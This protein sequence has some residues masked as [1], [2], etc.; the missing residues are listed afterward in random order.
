[1]PPPAAA[2]AVPEVPLSPVPPQ[3]S[4]V[5]VRASTAQASGDNTELLGLRTEFLG[6]LSGAAK[7]IKD[8]SELS[9]QQSKDMGKLIKAVGAMNVRQDGLEHNQRELWNNQQNDRK[10][11]NRFQVYQLQTNEGVNSRLEALELENALRNGGGAVS[12]PA[13]PPNASATASAV[14]AE[15]AD[16]SSP[17]PAPVPQVFAS[18]PA[19]SADQEM[20]DS[21]PSNEVPSDASKKMPSGAG[22]ATPQASAVTSNEAASSPFAS[23]SASSSVQAVTSPKKISATCSSHIKTT[24]PTKPTF[25]FGSP[26]NEAASSS[27][28]ASV[29][30]SSSVPVVASPKKISASCSSGAKTTT[31]T[32]PTFNMGFTPPKEKPN[33]KN[34]IKGRK[35]TTRRSPKAT[36]RSPSASS[37]SKKKA[38][39][40][41]NNLVAEKRK[42]TAAP[43]PV[44]NPASDISKS[45]TTKASNSAPV[46]RRYG[47]QLVNGAVRDW[48]DSKH[49][50]RIFCA[51]EL[52]AVAGSAFKYD[53]VS[54]YCA[55]LT[56]GLPNNF[57]KVA[58][59]FQN[60]VVTDSYEKL[61]NEYIT[62]LKTFR[63]GSEERFEEEIKKGIDIAKLK[64]GM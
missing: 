63:C 64:G 46:A 24:T 35:N 5:P 30:A 56:S 2:A 59:L 17:A 6:Y 48:D 21:A 41:R 32:E 43:S 10:I 45:V 18:Q 4:P 53:N 50:T 13:P 61:V 27:P 16:S 33:P 38:N 49:W 15:M 8:Q 55:E 7:C 58:V 20:D 9:N 22:A 54:Q 36:S 44:K 23:V 12:S 29:S 14:D 1:V 26:S 42:K 3:V 19:P 34:K 28:F 60:V 11:Q 37:S 51:L 57:Q 52:M 40:M 25:N 39:V 31:P 47:T 62:G